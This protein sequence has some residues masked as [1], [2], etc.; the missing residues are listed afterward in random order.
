MKKF[1]KGQKYYMLSICDRNA[2]WDFQ[3]INRTAKMVTLKDLVSNEIIKKKIN[4]LDGHEFCYPIGR[5]SMAPVL[6]AERE[7][8]KMKKNN[9]LVLKQICIEN[10]E[11]I[12]PCIT[13][14]ALKQFK[15]GQFWSKNF[16]RFINDESIIFTEIEMTEIYINELLESDNLKDYT[17]NLQKLFNDL[18]D[19]DGIYIPIEYLKNID[20]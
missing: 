13:E 16:E 9:E 10:F 6:K 19:D 8:L 5:Y 18:F 4:I 14:K 17:D 3:V 11:E 12:G 2:R 7:M 15:S 1:K 20:L